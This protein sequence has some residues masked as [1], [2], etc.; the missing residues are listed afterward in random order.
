MPFLLGCVEKDIRLQRP[1]VHSVAEWLALAKSARLDT[2]VLLG[3][4]RADLAWLQ[5]G[6]AVECTLKAAIMKKEGLNHWPD[7]NAA[8]DLWT[9]DL[10]DLYG[11]LGVVPAK[12]DP[13]H[14][15]APALRMTLEWQRE[16]GYAAGK[17]PIKYARD[18]CEAAFG[19]TGVIE[20]LAKK[21]QLNI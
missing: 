12:F 5:A 15:V 20:W 19:D 14:S 1:T 21:Y 18:L 6:F 9:H 13:K 3:T 16:H 8:P 10:I 17:L 4:R 2:E 7:K 11:R